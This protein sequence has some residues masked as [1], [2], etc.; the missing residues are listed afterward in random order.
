VLDMTAADAGIACMNGKYTYGFWRPVTAIQ[1][2]D[3]DGNSRTRGDPAWLPLT[4]TPNHPE[5]PSNHGCI[6]SAIAGALTAFLGTPA[7]DFTIDSTVTGTTQHFARAS[8]LRRQIVD[9]RIWAGL[10]FRNSMDAGVRIGSRV[11]RYA[12]SHYFLPTG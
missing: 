5:Y 12:T 9:A 2:G 6:T 8:A 7:I 4:V 10:H 3:D 1:Q 11:A